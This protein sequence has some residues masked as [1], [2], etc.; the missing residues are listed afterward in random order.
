MVEGTGLEVV[1]SSQIALGALILGKAVLIAHLLP[2]VN[3]FPDKPLAYNV[4]WKSAIYFLLASPIHYLVRVADSWK[5]A[6][7]FAAANQTLLAEIV[8]PHFWGIQIVVLVLI[9]NGCVKHEV[10]R[11]IGPA[12][13]RQIFFGAPRT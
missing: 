3:R 9:V 6:G 11:V 10:I 2:A 7:G 13:M 8:W 4:G 1:T 12:R 5:E